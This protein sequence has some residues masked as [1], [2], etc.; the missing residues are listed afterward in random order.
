MTIAKESHEAA[1]ATINRRGALAAFAAAPFIQTLATP[2]LNA[3]TRE[4]S[5]TV[6]GDQQSPAVGQ[7]ELVVREA[8]PE[9]LES[10]F[11]DLD[12]AITPTRRFFVRSHFA[13]PTLD[14]AS[15]RL[16]IDGE[17]NRPLQLSLK[18][19]TSMPSVTQMVTLECA[20]NGRVILKPKVDGLQWHQ[21]AVGNAEWTGVPLAHVLKEAGIKEGAME[22]VLSGA[23]SGEP[24]KPT[25][26]VGAIPFAR[27]LPLGEVEKVGVLLAWAMNGEPLTEAHG[28]PLRAVVPG[29]YGMASIKWLNRISVVST[30]FQGYFQSIDY[31]YWQQGTAGPSRI[32]VGRMQ[33][34]SQIARPTFGETLA[35]GAPYRIHGAAWSGGAD[36]VKVTLSLDGGKSFVDANLIG[37]PVRNAW[38]LWDYE[39]TPKAGT[40]MIFATAEDNEGR[41]Q[42]TAHDRNRESYMINHVQTLK[43]VVV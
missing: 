25:K 15:W 5:A 42:P 16:S 21:G 12:G 31:A 30:P 2:A 23:D 18:D 33:I 34:K 36:V 1:S 29:L 39:W 32:P 24:S 43:V 37:E 14:V 10:D 4:Q 13:A 17:V 40:H 9:N 7:V 8:N 20:G 28:F 3:Q 19:I 11:A 41:T 22:V 35:A 26:P 6:G 38:R 27:S